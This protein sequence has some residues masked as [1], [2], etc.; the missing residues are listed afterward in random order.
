MSI[1]KGSVNSMD[2]FWEV[3]TGEKSDY[4]A[5]LEGLCFAEASHSLSGEFDALVKKLKKPTLMAS[6]ERAVEQRP[7]KR[8]SARSSR[9]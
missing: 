3:M 2:Y 5:R 9:K 8:S 6:L 7:L 4:F 1:Q